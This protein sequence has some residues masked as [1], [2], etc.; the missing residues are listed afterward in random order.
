M[1]Y[2]DEEKRK[3]ADRDRQRRYRQQQKGVTKSV[4]LQGVTGEG[5]TYPDTC[6]YCKKPIISLGYSR[7][8]PG[9]CYDCSLLP[10][11]KTLEDLWP[12]YRYTPYDE[13][14]YVM[15]AFE[16]EHYKPAHKLSE[17]EHN[18]V[19]KPGDSHYRE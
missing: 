18:P 19:S 6:R 1:A 17:G 14:T 7:K 10:H 16:R 9:A 8:Y 5:V 2:K 15:T 11:P 4:T 13:S 12:R 3:Q